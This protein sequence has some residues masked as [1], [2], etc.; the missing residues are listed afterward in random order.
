MTDT[1]NSQATDFD[2]PW[3]VARSHVQSFGRIPPVFTLAIRSLMADHYKNLDHSSSASIF[4][5]NRL[6][7]SPSMK[8]VIYHAVLTFHGETIA[9]TPYLTC[10]DLVRMFKPGD[11]ASIIGI[12]YYFRL[13][14]RK[15]FRG[16]EE[17]AWN[18]L[19]RRILD[20]IDLGGFV[21]YCIPQITA[22]VGIISGSYLSLAQAMFL[23]LDR[24]PA[25][26]Y[27]S[28]IALDGLRPDFAYELKTWGCTSAQLAGNMLQNIGFGMP[29]MNAAI[30]NYA[31]LDETPVLEMGKDIAMNQFKFAIYW[32]DTLR[33]TGLAPTIKIPAEFYPS[34]QDMF[35][36]LYL[37]GQLAEKGTRFGWVNRSKDDISPSYT[38]QLYQEYLAE[39]ASTQELQDFC[40]T[41]ISPDLLEGIDEADFKA[42]TDRNSGNLDF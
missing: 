15:L 22:G 9:N 37:C 6:L 32:I 41:N 33:K 4:L 10:A 38:P 12:S 13:F 14:K 17:T 16:N 42:I 27:V 19:S 36:V 3:S 21:G 34:K 29:W 30:T 39:S 8:S 25:E 18:D 24:E 35:K 40:E 2:N 1:K 23:L 31:F 26:K 11:L 5:V 28:Q 20:D 7:L